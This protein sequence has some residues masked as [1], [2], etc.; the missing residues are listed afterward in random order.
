[1][2]KTNNQMRYPPNCH[3]WEYGLQYVAI[4]YSGYRKGPLSQAYTCLSST[5]EHIQKIEISE[6]L[7]DNLYFLYL[8]LS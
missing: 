1:M 7:L 3:V 6:I 2:V 4:H 5:Y 8:L